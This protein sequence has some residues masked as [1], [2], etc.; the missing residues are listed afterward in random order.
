MGTQ[1]RPLLPAFSCQ[2]RHHPLTRIC[3]PYYAVLVSTLDFTVH[4]AASLTST[5]YDA[6]YYH[7]DRLHSAP[8]QTIV[9]GAAE[10]T[11]CKQ[12]GSRDVVQ[13]MPR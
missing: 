9:S 3:P 12:K 6:S 1:E 4:G 5:G 10:N 11:S 8:T 13:N 2:E 7:T